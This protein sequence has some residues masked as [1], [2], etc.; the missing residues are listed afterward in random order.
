MPGLLA[1]DAAMNSSASAEV[2]A[3]M[4]TA[5]CSFSWSGG[6]AA[7]S[8]H[9]NE[10]YLAFAWPRAYPV[11]VALEGAA[12]FAGR[13]ESTSALGLRSCTGT[14]SSS[15]PDAN[16]GRRGDGYACAS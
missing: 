13:T 6:P 2:G 10:I 11:R 1:R 12:G 3:E 15:R 4:T 8:G 9:F 7:R 5:I 16:H 14:V